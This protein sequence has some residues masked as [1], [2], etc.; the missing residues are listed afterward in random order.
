LETLDF[1][2]GNEVNTVY[3]LMKRLE[4]THP[5]KQFLGTKTYK[6][7]GIE[8]EWITVKEMA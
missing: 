7:S 6:P 8:Y 5:N 3:R 4:S 2:K 1:L